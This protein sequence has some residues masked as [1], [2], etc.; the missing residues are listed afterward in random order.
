MEVEKEPQ[1]S[2][3]KL[4]KICML[5]IYR[6]Y[7]LC[8][9]SSARGSFLNDFIF[10]RGGTQPRNKETKA[11]VLSSFPKYTEIYAK[12]FEVVLECLMGLV[13]LKIV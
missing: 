9:Q 11:P 7:W 6:E 12:F 5:Y 10:L 1:K 2:R 4:K 8:P 13:A 3:P